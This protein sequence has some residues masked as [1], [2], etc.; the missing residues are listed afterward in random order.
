MV[1]NL[2]VEAVRMLVPR[3]LRWEEELVLERPK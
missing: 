1:I 3:L 2:W